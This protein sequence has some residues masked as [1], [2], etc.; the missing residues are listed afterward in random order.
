MNASGFNRR[1]LIKIL[2]LGAAAELARSHE[3]E[4]AGTHFVVPSNYQ[5]R[6]LTK[7]EY[8]LTSELCEIIIPSDDQ[9]PGAQQ[10]GVPWFIDTVLFYANAKR[11][12]EW[13]AGL[14]DID[15][16]AIGLKGVS[17]LECSH[18]DRLQVVE[19]LAQREEQ[20][21]TRAEKFFGELKA[22]AIE[23]FCLSD[24]GMS[25]YL[26]YR[27]NTALSEFPGCPSNSISSS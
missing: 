10:A 8:E 3:L 13:R 26:H 14:S 16:L 11:Q 19:H 2:G 7:S 18:A 21:D 15:A 20:A 17:F 4:S 1:E 9:S 6:F 25:Q 12:R 27:G 24:L 5:P 23:A 22:L